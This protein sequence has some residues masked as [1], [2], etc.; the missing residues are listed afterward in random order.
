VVTNSICG[1]QR[2]VIRRFLYE[3]CTKSY[4]DI[5]LKS[6][7]GGIALDTFLEIRY[8]LLKKI[9][10]RRYNTGRHNNGNYFF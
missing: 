6:M 9:D 10:E 8:I 2:I 4:L 5:D 1:L 7:E 3:R